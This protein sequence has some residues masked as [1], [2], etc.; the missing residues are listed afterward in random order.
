MRAK[1]LLFLLLQMI[2]TSYVIAEDDEFKGVDN[3]DHVC[4]FEKIY[5]AVCVTDNQLKSI[6]VVEEKDGYSLVSY[7]NQILVHLKPQDLEIPKN[8]CEKGK[9]PLFVQP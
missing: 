4:V 3:L 6:E 2:F 9:I 7:E 1:I 8:D 5:E